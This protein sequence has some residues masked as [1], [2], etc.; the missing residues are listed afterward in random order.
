MA[1]YDIDKKN[2][3][4]KKNPQYGRIICRCE[5]ITEAE[6]VDAIHRN[7]GAK[8]VAGVKNRDRAGAGRCQGGFCQ[9]VI[10]DILARELGKKH[11][12]IEYKKQHS[13]LLKG[14]TK[15]EKI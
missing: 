5:S 3:F 15:G 6:V 10:V 14:R 7:C 13:N 1:E 4:V 8:T 2:E 12:D 11:T 9:P